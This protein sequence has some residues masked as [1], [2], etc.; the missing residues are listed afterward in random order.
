M[1]KSQRFAQFLRAAVDVKIRKVAEVAKYPHVQWFSDLPQGLDEVR[2]PL[3]TT[4]WNSE[5]LRWLVVKRTTE[6]DLPKPPTACLP[7]LEGVE[8]TSPDAPPSLL[9]ERLEIGPD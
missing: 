4:G 3:I 2:S 6:S 5:D 9:S 8:L 1:T 7:W